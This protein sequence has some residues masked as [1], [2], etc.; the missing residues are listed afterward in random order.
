MRVSLGGTRILVWLVILRPRDINMQDVELVILA[1]TVFHSFLFSSI[2]MAWVSGSA[3]GVHVQMNT[4]S[5]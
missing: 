5:T 3:D 2:E 1:W 4:T